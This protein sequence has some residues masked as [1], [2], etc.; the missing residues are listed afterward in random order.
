MVDTFGVSMP[1]CVEDRHESWGKRGVVDGDCENRVERQILEQVGA[2][3]VGRGDDIDIGAVGP[4]VGEGHGYAGEADLLGADLS[5]AVA[6]EPHRVAERAGPRVGEVLGEVIRVRAAECRCRGICGVGPVEIEGFHGDPGRE[7]GG[8]HVDPER[9][10]RQVGN[11][12]HAVGVGGGEVTDVVGGLIDGGGG[13]VVADDA[14]GP[15]PGDDD[16]D[17]GER[18]VLIVE[19]ARPVGSTAP[20]SSWSNQIVSPMEPMPV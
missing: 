1:S 14:V 12:P 2:V 3:G 10:V 4:G 20:S 16:P 15:G 5:V 11:A 17:A 8:V 18:L 7:C 6:I 19:H 9:A 13:G